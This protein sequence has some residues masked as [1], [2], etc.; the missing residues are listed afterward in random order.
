MSTTPRTARFTT[1]DIS[2]GHC[3]LTVQSAVGALHGVQ[4]VEASS[5]TR[6]VAVTF[7][8]TQ[9]SHEQIEATLSDAGYPVQP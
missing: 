8:P 4:H 7:D 9:V 5:E 2:C 6:E 3:V 1:P